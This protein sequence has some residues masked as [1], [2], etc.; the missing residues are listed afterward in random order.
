M[1]AGD[2]SRMKPELWLSNTVPIRVISGGKTLD[3]NTPPK[4]TVYIER[5]IDQSYINTGD[6][7]ARFSLS[8]STVIFKDITVGSHITARSSKPGF[9]LSGPT[10]KREEICQGRHYCRFETW[11]YYVQIIG[12]CQGQD[13]EI[14]SPITG[15]DKRPLSSVIYIPEKLPEELFAGDVASIAFAI[16]ESFRAELTRKFIDWNKPPRRGRVEH[17]VDAF[18]SNSQSALSIAESSTSFGLSIGLASR[19]GFQS[20]GTTLIDGSNPEDKSE[21]IQIGTWKTDGFSV[22]M[23]RPSR[24]HF[25]F[26]TWSFYVHISGICRKIDHDGEPRPFQLPCEFDMP[27]MK[28]AGEPLT[29]FVGVFDTGHDSY[30]GKDDGRNKT[31]EAKTRVPKALGREGDFC[32]LDTPGAPK[33]QNLENCKEALPEDPPPAKEKKCY[34]NQA[35]AEN[36]RP[37]SEGKTALEARKVIERFGTYCK[38]ENG[39]IYDTES[40]RWLD[41]GSSEPYSDPGRPESDGCRAGGEHAVPKT[42]DRHQTMCKLDSGDIFD[43]ATGQWVRVET[44]RLVP[45]SDESKVKPTDCGPDD[46]VG[47]SGSEAE[48]ENLHQQQQTTSTSCKTVQVSFS[49][50]KETKWGE[51]VKIVGNA[52]ALKQWDPKQAVPLSADRYTQA[53]HE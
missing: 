34:E 25:H 41:H 12:K 7:I 50:L 46:A 11:T 38:V 35:R 21:Q 4:V 40:R 9:Q 49:V 39:D 1:E 43:W 18:R 30:N 17:Q 19:L 53:N 44:D 26:E 14:R 36:L 51:T 24:Y 45:Y 15:P 32:L 6:G 23:Q 22:S 31:M 28:G 2:E 16:E 42:I 27:L 3:K 5:F 10:Q 37:E 13:C 20:V 8:K 33:P 29:H 47:G 52:D 48:A